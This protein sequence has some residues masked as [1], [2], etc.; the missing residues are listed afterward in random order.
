MTF[1]VRTVAFADGEKIP[2]KYA[3]DGENLSPPLVWSGAPKGTRSFALI[4]ADPDAPSGTFYHW[5]AFDIPAER[6]GLPE[7]VGKRPAGA[8]HTATNDFRNSGYDGPQPPVGHGV[9]HYHF[10]LAALDVATLKLPGHARVPDVWA[11]AQKHA[12][13]TTQ[14]VGTYQR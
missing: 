7:G 1:S 13:A 9:H 10:R 3:R 5:A 2:A 4:V 12:L 11:E 14:L 8:F 6:T